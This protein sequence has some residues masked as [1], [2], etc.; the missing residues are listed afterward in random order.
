M[1]T[2]PFKFPDK[3][4]GKQRIGWLGVYIPKHLP[5]K[6]TTARAIASRA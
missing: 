4:T 1:A 5:S 3:Q 2:F 6:T